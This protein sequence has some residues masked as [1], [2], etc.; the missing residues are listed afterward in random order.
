MISSSILLYSFSTLFIK[1]NSSWLNFESIKV[2]EINASTLF[3]LDFANNIILSCFFFFCLIINFYFLTRAVIAQIF[4]SI[5]EFVIPVGTSIKEA[6]SEM[7]T[8]PV[9]LEITVSKWSAKLCKF[10]Y[11]SYTLIYFDL[12]LSINNFLFQLFFESKFLTCIFFRHDYIFPDNLL[13]Y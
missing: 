6:K 13:Y 3:D 5:P 8:H 7:V 9:I 10:F 12:F 4:N 11:G 2:L 1:T